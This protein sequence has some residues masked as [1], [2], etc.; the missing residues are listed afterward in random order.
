MSPQIPSAAIRFND[1][2]QKFNCTVNGIRCK[3][4]PRFYHPHFNKMWIDRGESWSEWMVN[5]NNENITTLWLRILHRHTMTLPV[6][7]ETRVCA[8]KKQL[9]DSKLKNQFDLGICEAATK[10]HSEFNISVWMLSLCVCVWM[11]DKWKKIEKKTEHFLFMLSAERRTWHNINQ[12]AKK[13]N[14]ETEK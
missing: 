13:K 4:F 11:N 8:T 6:S 10:K 5:T 1:V 14:A 7:I 2:Q 9:S 3:L 12:E